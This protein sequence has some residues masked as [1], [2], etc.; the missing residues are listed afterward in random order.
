[1]A[2]DDRQWV[3]GLLDTWRAVATAAL[4]IDPDPLP[5]I[6]VFDQSCMW[7]V[8]ARPEGTAHGG[9]LSLPDGG[10]MPATVMARAGTAGSSDQPYV[11][12]AL[13]SI[14]RADPRYGGDANLP[15]LMRTAFVHEMAHTVQSRAI[16]GWLGAIVQ[17]LPLPDGIDGNIIQTR[18]EQ[19][20]EFRASWVAERTLLYQAANE[21]VASLRRA[22]LGTAVAMVQTR[23]ARY[24]SG[25]AAVLA[26]LEDLYLTVE[27][28][29][30]WVG[31]Q[32][33]LSEGMS[34]ADAQ[35]FIRRDRTQWSRDEGFAAFLVVD[36]LL[37]DWRDRVLQGRPAPMLALLVEAARR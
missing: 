25:D 6:V 23:R 7:Q 37:P 35:S 31:Y 27:G 13:P 29:G 34:P 32:V 33:A 14:W 24:F 18:F 2:A 4:R 21:P 15:L 3:E 20:A 30:S 19:N 1:M 28:L 9:T 5:L 26:E 16:G 11:V 17:R 36:A 8:G 12:M 10:T 22:L